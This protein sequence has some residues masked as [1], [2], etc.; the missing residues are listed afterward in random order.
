MQK[1]DHVDLFNYVAGKLNR[2]DP[3]FGPFK[4][5][6]DGGDSWKEITAGSRA[7]KTNELQP[8][9]RRRLRQ[10]EPA[11]PSTTSRRSTDKIFASVEP[12][13]KVF[14]KAAAQS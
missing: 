6:C 1:L 4:R 2:D 3:V 13:G 11:E 14:V 10:R 7:N 9:R 8:D 5:F 12:K